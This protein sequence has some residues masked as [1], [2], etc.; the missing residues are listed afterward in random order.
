MTQWTRQIKGSWTSPR[1][2]FYRDDR[3]YLVDGHTLFTEQQWAVPQDSFVKHA[4]FLPTRHGTS[5]KVLTLEGHL[6][7]VWS[8]PKAMESNGYTYDDVT[9]VTMMGFRTVSSSC[10]LIVQTYQP[11][12]TFLTNARSH[13]QHRIYSLLGV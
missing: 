11:C 13:V 6:L 4:S 9:E 10:Q 12:R 8:P 5:V 2:L 1:D 3:L 7:Q